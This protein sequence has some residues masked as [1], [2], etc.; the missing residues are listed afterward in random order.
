MISSIISWFVV[1]GLSYLISM[2]SG[3]NQGTIFCWLYCLTTP[4]ILLIIFLIM[5][6]ITKIPV[7][8]YIIALC[9]IV[10]LIPV[11]LLLTL[12]VS[13]LFGISFAIAFEIIT[14]IYCFINNKQP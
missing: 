13:K 11:L 12:G 10:I 8:A 3:G 2:L 7:V 4:I 1:F 6:R 9:F 5:S 14:F